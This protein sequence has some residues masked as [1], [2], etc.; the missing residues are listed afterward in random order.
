MP[1]NERTIVFISY[2]HADKKWL[3]ELKQHLTP[4]QRE[5]KIEFWDDSKIPPGAV[6]KE[7][8]ENAINSCKAAILLISANFFASDYIYAD[9]L[10][11]LLD[12][13][14]KQ[15]ATI[16]PL[17]VSPSRF[18]RSALKKFQTVN[19]PVKPLS[20]INS[21]DRNELYDKVAQTI[22]ELFREPPALP[23]KASKRK[24][25]A[26]S[27]SKK[28]TPA[29]R[30]KAPVKIPAALVETSEPQFLAEF[31]MDARGKF[32]LSG[33]NNNH[34]EI[35]LFIRNASPDTKRVVYKLHKT[36]EEP[37]REARKGRR[38]FEEYITT[39]GDYRIEVLIDGK[40]RIEMDDWLTSALENFYGKKPRKAIFEAI[41]YI[42][43][44]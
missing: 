39:Y 11:P 20:D 44:H 22:E 10:P 7:E 40:E 17:I 24:P 8:I 41:K 43:E 31:V 18:L 5:L 25:A 9:E 12:A 30:K 15:G 3:K 38:E 33:K 16:L 23:A 4:V 37:T 13:A 6:W 32:R 27:S 29:K 1:E 21:N 19:N 36:Y 14:E 26:A 35:R 42:E 34:Y 2:S 28:P